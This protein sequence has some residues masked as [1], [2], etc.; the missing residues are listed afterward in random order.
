MLTSFS[1]DLVSSVMAKVILSLNMCVYIYI[2]IYIYI[3]MS[4]Q[5]THCLTLDSKD[6]LLF[7]PKIF[8]VYVLYLS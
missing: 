2:Y 1:G 5:K 4:S 6:F 7:F 3:Y 8:N